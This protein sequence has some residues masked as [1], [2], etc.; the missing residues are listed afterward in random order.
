MPVFSYL[1]TPRDGQGKKLAEKLSQLPQCS[2]YPSETHEL[3]V[4]V[5]DTRDQTAEEA[6]LSRLHLIDELKDLS[7]VF[8]HEGKEPD[9]H[10]VFDQD[11]DR[12][13]DQD[14]APEIDQAI[15]QP[16]EENS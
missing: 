9:R 11:L 1:A 7:M 8:G 10:Q 13:M 14:I 2:I 12:N 6:F 15:D 3:I 16:P 5:T 4:L